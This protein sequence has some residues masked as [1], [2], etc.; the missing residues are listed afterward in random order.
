MAKDYKCSA[1]K[2]PVD[3]AATVCPNAVCRANLAFCSHCRD[4]ST[5]T[6]VEKGEGRFGRD[7]YRCDRCERFG[8]KCLSWLSGGYCNGLA[9]AEEQGRG[10]SLCAVCS[11][12][13]GEMGRSV[14]GWSI[15]GAVGGF[16][17][18]KR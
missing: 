13:L 18:P 6:L 11:H 3:Q 2:E 4:I 8:V 16:L 12:R 5:Y 1:C 9:R 10:K 17:R 14:V 15:I 7:R